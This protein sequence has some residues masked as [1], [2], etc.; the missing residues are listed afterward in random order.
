VH[1]LHHHTIRILKVETKTIQMRPNLAGYT[2]RR[3]YS[4]F[5]GFL[6][7]RPLLYIISSCFMLAM[8]CPHPS[9]KPSSAIGIVVVNLKVIMHQIPTSKVSTE[10]AVNMTCLIL[11]WK[12]P[13]RCTITPLRK[14]KSKFLKHIPT[15]NLAHFSELQYIANC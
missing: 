12:Q 8:V 14:I 13:V 11:I 4:I 1:Y 7:A 10:V 9:A 3:G 5:R 6:G 2:S 15:N